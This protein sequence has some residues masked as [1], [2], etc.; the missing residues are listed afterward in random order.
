MFENVDGRRTDEGRPSHGMLLAHLGSGKLNRTEG[1][2]HFFSK[3]EV[4]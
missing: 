4:I 1:H 3:L 2:L